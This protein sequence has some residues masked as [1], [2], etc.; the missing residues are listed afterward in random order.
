MGCFCMGNNVLNVVEKI[1]ITKK[2]V[3]LFGF[4][5]LAFMSVILVD[6]THTRQQIKT[7]EDIF[8]RGFGRMAEL[9]KVQRHVQDIRGALGG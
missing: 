9:S 5:W 8:V 6:V 3:M 7:Q 2:L 4:I 1:S